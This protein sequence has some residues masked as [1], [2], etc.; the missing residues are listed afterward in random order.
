MN[1]TAFRV[2]GDAA[3]SAP[4]S[5]DGS[6]GQQP[7]F[8]RN[9]IG[10]TARP[11]SLSAVVTVLKDAFYWKFVEYGTRHMSA[12]PMFRPAADGNRQDHHTR[13]IGALTRANSQ[14]EREGRG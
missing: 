11:R 12:R 9:A 5:A 13:M 1:V 7:G 14:M 3:R 2:S 6:H 4:V 10:W 8:L